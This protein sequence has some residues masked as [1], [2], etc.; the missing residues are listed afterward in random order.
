MPKWVTEL[1]GRWIGDGNSGGPQGNIEIVHPDDKSAKCYGRW[2]GA[3]GG[4]AG[5]EGRF[6]APHTIKGQWF[7]SDAQIYDRDRLGITI[8]ISSEKNSI[9][10]KAQGKDG[11][12]NEWTARRPYIHRDGGKLTIPNGGSN[13]V[14]WRL[15]QPTSPRRPEWLEE[16]RKQMLQATL[17]MTGAVSTKDLKSSDGA[18][19]Y[20]PPIAICEPFNETA[21]KLYEDSPRFR[22]R[23]MYASLNVLGQ[24][25]TVPPSPS[26]PY[27]PRPYMTI[28]DV[29]RV[30]RLEKEK[31]EAKLP[32][33]L[34]GR[35]KFRPSSACGPRRPENDIYLSAVDALKANNAELIKLQKLAAEQGGFA[36]LPRR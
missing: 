25:A 9:T 24:P 13:E 4:P 18:I 15:A 19:T 32:A 7:D 12:T 22:G 21:R 16:K 14:F 34:K 35:K 3:K 31:Q 36:E 33:G 27:L 26:F 10:V 5:F 2:H 30:L 1:P 23:Q 28:T 29:A 17:Q 8:E 6:A 11:S 20:I